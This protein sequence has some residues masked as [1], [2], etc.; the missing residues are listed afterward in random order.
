[1]E[2]HEHSQTALEI[3]TL[4]TRQQHKNYWKEVGKLLYLA[5]CT[6]QG[7]PFANCVFAK[8][9]HAC[10]YCQCLVVEELHLY[11]C[12]RRYFEVNL[13]FCVIAM[14]WEVFSNSGWAART[15]TIKS[16]N[17][18]SILMSGPLIDLNYMSKTTVA[19][20]SGETELI[21]LSVMC[22]GWTW[23]LR[24]CLEITAALVLSRIHDF[25]H[26]CL[27]RQ[28]SSPCGSSSAIDQRQKQFHWSQMSSSY[29][30]SSGVH[31][32][33]DQFY[34]YL[35]ISEDG[36]TPYR[37][38]WLVVALKSSPAHSGTILTG[39][40]QQRFALPLLRFCIYEVVKC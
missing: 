13:G 38:C 10:A 11:P 30:S 23:L 17:G 21:A 40:G 3:K 4:L 29:T 8:G 25:H 9:P 34:F 22:R 6:R 14:K 39:L 18:T 28:S 15:T 16:T 35:H 36:Q 31:L 37:P 26:C 27:Y 7:I 24:I 2:L 1:M 32:Y 5:V 12:T 20:S 19:L 33:F